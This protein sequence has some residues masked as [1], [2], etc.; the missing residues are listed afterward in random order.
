MFRVLCLALLAGCIDAPGTG[1]IVITVM[2]RDDDAPTADG[3]GQA[4]LEIIVDEA[5]RVFRRDVVVQVT[6]ASVG[7][8][9]PLQLKAPDDGRLLLPIRYGRQPG[10]VRIEVRAGPDIAVDDSFALAPR[11]P[12]RVVP[13]PPA[14]S[15]SG[16]GGDSLLLPVELIVDD[17]AARPSLGT[18][19]WFTAC[20]A[21]PVDC[22]TPLVQV[23]PL[24]TMSAEADQVALQ[25]TAVAQAPVVEPTTLEAPVAIGLDGPPTCA[26]AAAFARLTVAPP[27]DPF[28]GP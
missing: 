9:G 23:S 3:I 28:A 11:R 8:G 24:A 17:P 16:A 2:P 6:G 18:R 26:D 14:R 22:A 13:H 7:D 27:I 21:G 4:D 15:L 5:A 25:A 1:P 10:P 20:C 12:D 19:V